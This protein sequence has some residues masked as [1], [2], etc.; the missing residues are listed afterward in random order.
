MNRNALFIVM[1]K[2]VSS[3]VP[4]VIGRTYRLGYLWPQLAVG[5]VES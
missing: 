4:R 2:P 3:P 1:P 5:C